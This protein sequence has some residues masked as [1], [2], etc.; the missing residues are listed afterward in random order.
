MVT[1]KWDGMRLWSDL[2]P[3]L[4]VSSVYHIDIEQLWAQGVRG[5][6]TDLDNTLVE[7][8]EHSA[9]PKLVAWLDHL[10]AKGFRVCIVSNNEHERVATFA[11]PLGIPCVAKAGKPRRRGLKEALTLLDVGANQAAMIG[12][13]VFTDVWGGNR[14][15]MYTILVRPV[16]GQQHAATRVIRRVEKWV[17]RE[18]SVTDGPEWAHDVRK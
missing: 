2:L 15:R 8:N 7:W 1:T 4:Y 14:M 11:E 3:R 17:L 9:A 18:L 13:Q 16:A 12:D 5:I 6:A 10:R